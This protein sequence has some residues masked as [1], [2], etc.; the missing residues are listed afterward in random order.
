MSGAITQ[1]GPVTAG[2]VAMFI[3]NG[4][5]QDAGPAADGDIT[6]I[7]ITNPGGLALGINSGLAEFYFNT[8]TR[9]ARMWDGVAWNNLR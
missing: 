1:S 2:H 5:V 9:K 4:T 6:Q 3:A 8:V 7:G